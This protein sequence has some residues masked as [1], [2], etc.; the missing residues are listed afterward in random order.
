MVSR[1][2]GGSDIF[3][4]GFQGQDLKI[5]FILQVKKALF[6]NTYTD[7]RS[8]LVVYVRVRMFGGCV[9]ILVSLNGEICTAG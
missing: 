2:L 9:F 1:R 6:H 4:P 8:L 7:I 5:R 3:P